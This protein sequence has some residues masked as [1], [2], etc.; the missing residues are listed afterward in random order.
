MFIWF[1]FIVVS[2]ATK[3]QIEHSI[4]VKLTSSI[5]IIRAMKESLDFWK[6]LYFILGVLLLHI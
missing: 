1:N 2:N 5:K 4:N 3:L 6:D